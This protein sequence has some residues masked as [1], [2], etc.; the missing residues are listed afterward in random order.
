MLTHSQAVR[1]LTH[2]LVSVRANVG[3]ALHVVLVFNKTAQG[4]SP[5]GPLCALIRDGIF[6]LKF[7]CRAQQSC[8][9]RT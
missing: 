1:L 2:C 3:F 7:P 4:P 5:Q 6:F 9:S 8:L